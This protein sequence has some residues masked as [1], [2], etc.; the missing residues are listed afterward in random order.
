MCELCSRLSLGVC[1]L[2]FRNSGATDGVEAGVGSLCSRL[3]EGPSSVSR[4]RFCAR[5]MLGVTLAAD[6][7]ER[8]GGNCDEV[9]WADPATDCGRGTLLT[10]SIA[11]AGAVSMPLWRMTGWS[12]LAAPPVS[13]K[14]SFS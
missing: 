9:E 10:E 13:R 2:G 1:K 12:S 11:N 14:V 8:V 7:K 4:L 3:G 5:V 6:G